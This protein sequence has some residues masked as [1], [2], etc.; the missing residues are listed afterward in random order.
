MGLHT[1]QW[2]LQR[3]PCQR[4]VV[5]EKERVSR[6]RHSFSK[7]EINHKGEIYYRAVLHRGI[8]IGQKNL[9]RFTLDS[10]VTVQSE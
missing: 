10:L 9:E 7:E 2:S 8:S 4:R 1:K 6:E 5:E 3:L